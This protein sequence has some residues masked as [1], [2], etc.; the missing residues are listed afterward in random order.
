MYDAGAT[1]SNNVPREGIGISTHWMIPNTP[2]WGRVR[3]QRFGAAAAPYFRTAL[4]EIGHAMGLYHNTV[5]FGIMNTTDVISAGAVLPQQFP[6][7]VKWAHAD[8][9][10]KRLKHLPDIWVRPG[11]IPFG[12]SY[13]TAPI[14]P[15]DRYDA[16]PGVDFTATP[17]LTTVPI[18]A[19]VRVNLMLTNRTARPLLLPADLGLR[20]GFVRGKV[21][22]PA[23]TVRSFS[24]LILCVDEE[25]MTAVDPEQSV[26]ES[27]T[28][29]RGGEG[30]LFPMAGT[31]RISIELDWDA[32]AT[33][34]G[35]TAEAVVMVTPAVDE[36]H[37][38]AA[39]DVL[40]E[41]DTLPA[42]VIGGDHLVDGVAAIRS[43]V[44]NPVLAPHFAIIEA[45]RVAKSAGKR[46]PVPEDVAALLDGGVVATEP[47]I[48]RLAQLVADARTTD[49]ARKKIAA[50]LKARADDV[51]A[52]PETRKALE[53]LEP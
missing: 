1:D 43:A 25:R 24:P 51:G 4:H 44:N 21:V 33:T 10:R 40:C 30:A 23:G 19:P 18:G 7:N 31:Y 38:E 11:G 52:G 2:V 14:S 3:G 50:A 39:L 32:G 42:M 45:K 48:R 22:D 47:E 41:P 26:T 29:L 12:P 27:L 5:D 6:D 46:K 34:V 36:K 37:A 8:D 9:D 13:G 20:G 53:A 35:T 15:D 49:G 16:V 28:L 17:L